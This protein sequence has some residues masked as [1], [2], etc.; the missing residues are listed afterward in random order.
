M[1]IFSPQ[2]LQAYTGGT[3]LGGRVPAGC[4]SGF[5]QDSRL[6]KSGMCFV[7]LQTAQRDG[8]AFLPA[9]LEAGAAMAL[10]CRADA[11]CPLPQLVVADTLRAFQQIARSHRQQFGGRVIGV[12]GSCGKTS[13]KNMLRHLLEPHCHATEGNLNNF[14]GVPLTLLGLET[15]D[16]RDGDC[17]ANRKGA[18]A[19][20]HADAS[21][22]KHADASE[23]SGKAAGSSA[24]PQFAVIEAGISEP[25]EMAVLADMIRPEIALITM[26][27]PAHLELLG[28]IEGVAT[29]KIALA[30]AQ[31]GGETV[32]P[33]PSSASVPPS[34][35]SAVSVPSSSPVRPAGSAPAGLPQ[36]P[37]LS[38]RQASLPLLLA[39]LECWQYAAFAS[40]ENPA[41]VVAKAVDM[42]DLYSQLE[43]VFPHGVPANVR[44][45]RFAL[46]DGGHGAVADAGRA[47][48]ATTTAADDDGTGH[49]AVVFGQC[50]LELEGPLL[51]GS[52]ALGFSAS[53]GMAGNV[54]LALL[55]AHVC[56][57]SQAQLAQRIAL[58]QPS[59]NRG[60][61]VTQGGKHFFVDCYNANPA[62]MCDALSLFAA[63]SGLRSA[64]GTAQE[65]ACGKSRD[66]ADTAQDA[67]GGE[68]GDAQA[69]VNGERSADAASGVRRLFVLGGMRELG[70]DSAHWHRMVGEHLGKLLAADAGN[71]AALACGSGDG[72]VHASGS[73]ND[74]AFAHGSGN[75]AAHTRNAAGELAAGEFAVKNLVAA[76]RTGRDVVVLIGTGEDNTA[77]EQGIRMYA[78]DAVVHS[79]TQTVEARPL[80]EAFRG[81][82]FLKGSRF[83]ALES[84]LAPLPPA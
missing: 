3:W 65:S 11:N 14:I 43:R 69:A 45:H 64:T 31:D 56:G 12:T 46:H 68:R 61:W 5:T 57:I 28:S 2:Q 36:Q 55:A 53:E 59:G 15:G 22:G 37:S 23:G 60:Q 13:A 70:A 49:A 7:A 74:A 82:V 44:A 35:S 18:G 78:A 58:W 17:C 33:S 42:G 73:D 47:T 20:N 10:V 83:Y 41:L 19:G 6:L 54:A 66:A 81:A 52:F 29:E 75:G 21:E 77:L 24:P 48:A 32:P 76:N 79:F 67:V 9:A 72:T 30:A 1:P 80:V 50:V 8:H 16:D 34:L 27:G 39:P 38:L 4:V 62:S 25:G 63:S 71:G 84:L 26:V 51:S 40:S